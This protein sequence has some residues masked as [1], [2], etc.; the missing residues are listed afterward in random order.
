MNYSQVTQGRIM[1]QIDH[2]VL[3]MLENRSLDNVLGWLYHGSQPARVVPSDSSPQFNGLVAGRDFNEYRSFTGTTKLAVHTGT[4]G[5][6]QPLRVPRLNPHEDYPNVKVQ[7]FGD[8]TGK[9]G[10]RASMKGFA[11]NFDASYETWT[12]LGEVMGAYGER[13]LPILYGLARSYGVSDRWFSSAPTQTN[14][15][16][17]FAHCGTSL[18]RESNQRLSAREQ[19]DCETVWNVL[20]EGDDWA[21]Y[22]HDSAWQDGKCYTEYT[23]PKIDEAKQNG[24]IESIEAFYQL[25][26]LPRFTFIEPAWGYGKGTPATF[27]GVQG[28]DYHPPTWCG[29]GEYFLNRVYEKLISLECW[30]N[31]L[32]IVTFDEHGGTYDHVSPPLGAKKP[33]RH[34]G[35]SG[36]QFNRFG[37][38]VPTLLVSPYVPES[39]VFRASGPTPF[40]HTS[41]ISSLLKW[42]GVPSESWGLGNRV[43]AAPT[44]EAAL[45]DTPRQDTPR[46]QVPS[47]YQSQGGG[48]KNF[49]NAAGLPTAVV[50]GIA[51]SPGTLEEVEAQ[52]STWPHTERA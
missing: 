9:V 22:Y 5:W 36:F 34:T 21:I 12:E 29:P 31:T 32:F 40:D 1:P 51:D 20:P 7:L 44:F 48:I 39:T 18:G 13:Q 8:A 14:P 46:F 11:Y 49:V 6:P 24:T 33:D 25:S 17:A 10:S 3:L 30:R 4:Q 52:L 38:R 41:I 26:S 15:N 47:G 2:V 45:S 37:V 16:R 28:N 27:V 23:F 42:R 43:A 19:F 50:K 35:E